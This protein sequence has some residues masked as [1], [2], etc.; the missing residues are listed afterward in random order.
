MKTTDSGGFCMPGEMI[1]EKRE[2][3]FRYVILLILLLLFVLS[4]L[5]HNQADLAVLEHGSDEPIRNL[6]GPVGAKIARILFYLF[7]LAIYPITL[8][9][10]FCLGRSFIRIPTRR[11]GYTGALAAIILGITILMAMWPQDMVQWTEQLGIGHSKAPELALSGGVIGAKL[12]APG[13]DYLPAGLIR[14]HIGTVGTLIVAMTFLLCGLVFVFLADWKDIV[15]SKFDFKISVRKKNAE[16]ED[17]DQPLRPAAAMKP[18]A[19]L[20]R[21]E[22]YRPDLPPVGRDD[23][24][25]DRQAQ[26][27]APGLAAG[28]IPPVE[29]VKEAGQLLPRHRLLQGVGHRQHL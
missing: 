21:K 25:G 8:F 28:L 13:N 9:L 14:R 2:F 29:P 26:A 23:A 10:L 12:A 15:F 24:P 16:D 5:S 3:K 11:K 7:G 19:K 27:V 6:I 17:D 22:P 4:I 18:Q 20:Q 1:E